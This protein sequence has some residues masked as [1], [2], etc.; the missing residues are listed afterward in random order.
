MKRAL[1]ILGATA[2]LLACSESVVAPAHDDFAPAFSATV[3]T[4]NLEVPFAIAVFISCALDGAGEVALLSG[5]LHV[6]THVTLNDAGGFTVKTHF[7][8]QNLGGTGLTSGDAYRGVGVTQQTQTVGAGGLPF[9]FT[10]V[11]NFRMI[12]Q[13]PG[14]NFQVHQ[15][16]HVTVN[17]NGVVT[18]A[19]DNASVTC[20]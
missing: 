1:S 12:G 7:Q 3:A 14:N 19:I 15:N 10:F 13:G 16:V 9:E 5:T 6:L 2:M 11:N 20:G 4:T 18:A 17:K 8:P